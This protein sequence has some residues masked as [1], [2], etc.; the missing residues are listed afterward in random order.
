LTHQDAAI[1]LAVDN[2]FWD[3]YHYLCIWHIFQN[4]KE[5]MSSYMA[6]KE[7]MEDTIVSLI[8][9]SLHTL[10]FETGWKEMLTTFDCAD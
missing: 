6:N 4:L 10:E 2:V 3:T 9:N 7:G 5:N 1:K 8:M